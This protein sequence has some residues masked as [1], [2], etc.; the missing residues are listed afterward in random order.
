M[1]RSILQDRVLAMVLKQG[2]QKMGGQVSIL[3]CHEEKQR[4]WCIL[5]FTQQLV[6][7]LQVIKWK[8]NKSLMAVLI[9]M[10]WYIWVNIIIC[11]CT[12]AIQLPMT[13]VCDAGYGSSLWE[14]QVIHFSFKY[15]VIRHPW[16]RHS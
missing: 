12:K 8:S 14:A 13:L 7:M 15:N 16:C 6:I 10:V 1:I 2:V 9:L 5:I 4:K 11:F 3:L